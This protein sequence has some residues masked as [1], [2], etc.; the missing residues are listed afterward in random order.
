ML[1]KAAAPPAGASGDKDS[2]IIQEV[3]SE[4]N[5]RRCERRGGGPY[6]GRRVVKLRAGG[7]L[8]PAT[9]PN[10]TACDEH[11]SIRE[12]KLRVIE[13]GNA[14]RAAIRPSA[15]HGI[16]KL[17]FWNGGSLVVATGNQNLAVREQ[18]G[19]VKLT[20]VRQTSRG[21]P[22]IGDGIANLAQRG[23]LR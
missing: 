7:R 16:V 11:A 3:R 14:N 1:S 8:F 18:S 20:G 2:S 23:Y 9:A 19:P 5:S 13:S 6:P 10:I 21:H 4:V 22:G 15:C 12:G 17:R